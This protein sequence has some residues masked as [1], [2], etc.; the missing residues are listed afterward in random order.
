MR[1]HRERDR[2]GPRGRGPENRQGSGP[3]G[4]RAEPADEGDEAYGEHE[5]EVRQLERHRRAEEET[6]DRRPPGERPRGPDVGD[7]ELRRLEE[8]GEREEV[9]H[10]ARDLP[11][12]SLG[13]HR[14]E[15]GRSP[16]PLVLHRRAS[17]ASRGSGRTRRA[18]ARSRPCRPDSPGPPGTS[19]SRGPP[20]DSGTGRSTGRS[21]RAGTGVPTGPAPRASR[22]S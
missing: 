22:G 4:P 13:R 7:R 16:G 6:Q 1:G 2:H 11:E 15:D 5:D 12:H 8:D 20:R 21:R 10:V 19:R 17:G 14:E 3:L 18:R 9:D